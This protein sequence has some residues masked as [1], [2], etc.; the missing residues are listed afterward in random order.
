MCI[1][2][3]QL[4]RVIKQHFPQWSCRLW[5]PR[6]LSWQNR[7]RSLPNGHYDND[8]RSC[9]EL[10][11]RSTLKRR[12]KPDRTVHLRDKK[13]FPRHQAYWS[14]KKPNRVLCR[15]TYQYVWGDSRSRDRKYRARREQ[16]P[17]CYAKWSSPSHFWGH[18]SAFSWLD[19]YSF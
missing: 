1:S 6:S 14:F 4:R 18:H 10:G 17:R 15:R 3:F 16:E 5:L 19:E 11:R 7:R 2:A 9:A 8:V 12:R 13:Y